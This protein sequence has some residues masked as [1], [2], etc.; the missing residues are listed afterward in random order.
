VD[1]NSA[2]VSFCAAQH[3]RALARVEIHGAPPVAW[4][5]AVYRSAHDVWSRSP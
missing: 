3:D 5:L 4:G 1:D 2:V